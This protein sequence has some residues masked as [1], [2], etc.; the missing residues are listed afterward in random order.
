MPRLG[1]VRVSGV[2]MEPTLLD[3]DV[4]LVLWGA[5]PRP[6]S[7]VVCDLPP[8]DD[9]CPRPLAVKRLTGPAPG[10]PAGR[11]WV[12]RDN[13][14]VGVDSWLVGS[15]PTSALRARVLLRLPRITP[16]HL[17]RSRSRR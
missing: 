15:L 7:L 10:E 1:L 16:G 2:S 17:L 11:W 4:L 9:G 13:P 3:G 14:R 5:A 8:D 6:G 12:E